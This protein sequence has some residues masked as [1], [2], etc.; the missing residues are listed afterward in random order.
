MPASRCSPN[1]WASRPAAPGPSIR[2]DQLYYLPSGK[3]FE[4]SSRAIG[5]VLDRTLY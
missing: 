5:E 2:A 4:A 1:R 3:G